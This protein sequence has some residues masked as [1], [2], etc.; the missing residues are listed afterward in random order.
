MLGEKE[1]YNTWEYWSRHKQVEMKKKITKST[2]EEQGSF[3]KPG[4][5]AE[6]KG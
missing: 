3:L 6:S 4:T 1:N 2:S 5:V